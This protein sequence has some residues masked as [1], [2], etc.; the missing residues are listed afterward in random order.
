MRLN[1][2]QFV[3]RNQLQCMRECCNREEGNHFKAMIYDL[4]NTI[5]SM[6]KTY[7]TEGKGNEATVSLHYFKGGS[8]WYIIERDSEN[9]QLQA[10]GF[11]CLNG[12]YEMAELGYIN[13]QE[14]IRHNVELD[15]YYHPETLASV[16]QRFSDRGD[17]NGKQPTV[18]T[19]QDWMMEA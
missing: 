9:E 8:D 3:G 19:L 5:A 11:A 1:L 10:F 13:I 18:E 7:E 17:W 14:L 2:N 12:D 15:L 16:K 4:K 6:P